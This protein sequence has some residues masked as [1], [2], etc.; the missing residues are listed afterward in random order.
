VSALRLALL[1][2]GPALCAGVGLGA[3]DHDRLTPIQAVAG[4]G[5]DFAAIAVGLIVWRRRPE[6]RTGIL[7]VLFGFAF[8][9]PDLRIVF[10]GSPAAQTAG[11]A[12][13][14]VVVP[15]FGLLVLSYPTGRLASRVDRG[16]VV[17]GFSLAAGYA[18][19]ELLFLSPRE[20]HAGGYTECFECADPWTHVKTYDVLG[21][22][23][24]LDVA[25][26][27]LALLF[28]V[29]LVRKLLVTTRRQ[30]EVVLPLA[31][32]GTF[33]AVEF[34]VQISVFGAQVDSWT[35]RAWFWIVVASTLVVPLSLAAG[36]LWGRGA[37]AAVADL[38]L[39][40]ERTPPVPVRDALARTLGDPSLELALW[41]PEQRAFVDGAGD[42][43]DPTSSAERT[44]TVLGPNDSP[45]AALIHDPALLERRALLDSAGAAARLALENERLQAELRAQLVEIRRSRAR[46]VEA[47]DQERRRLERDLHDGAQQRLL[48]LGLA[49]QLAR[50]RL[51]AGGNGA[52]DLLA[53]ADG[54]LRAALDELRELAQGIHPAVLTEQGLGPALRTLA[55]RSPVP[56]RI[57]SVPD[58]RLPGPAE[59]AVYFLVSEA[60]ANVAKH[61]QATSVRLRVAQAGSAV[62][63]ELE[64]DG[65]G[66]A[67]PDG[68][69]LRGLADRVQALDGTVAIVS[70]PGAGTRIRAEIPCA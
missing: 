27:V 10:H 55:E 69:G 32:A 20:P 14:E 31:F 62:A 22:R 15:V 46:I 26:S 48:S 7:L 11:M 29:R 59:A 16:L 44:V 2:A 34:I 6:S 50:A 36:L 61:A 57:E 40:L 28:L 65:V 30:R 19:L 66:G 1:L 64:D 21:I 38:V 70:E 45:L 9:L 42:R 25:I 52:D 24:G 68:S 5:A 23:D 43:V 60:L 67:N 37:R 18:L 39:E 35:N 51:G 12:A 41:L 47:G 49:L 8:A 53:E 13:I 3:V 56:V 17:A 58:E 54:E 4:Y 63:V 33:V